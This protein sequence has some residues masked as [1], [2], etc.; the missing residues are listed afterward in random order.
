MKP[1]PYQIE[2]TLLPAPDDPGR[3]CYE[4]QAKLLAIQESL[5]DH[6]VNVVTVGALPS[7]DTQIGQFIITLGPAAIP[8]IAAIAGAWIETRS[9]RSVGLRLDEAEAEVSTV[10]ALGDFLKGSAREPTRMTF[11]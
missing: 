11:G 1:L 8:A 6:R 4:T 7:G 9:G 5:R 3:A 2:L 10:G